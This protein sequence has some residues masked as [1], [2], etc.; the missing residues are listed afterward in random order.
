MEDKKTLYKR[1]RKIQVRIT[2]AGTLQN[3]IA[4]DLKIAK[5]SL[6]YFLNLKPSYVTKSMCDRLEKYLEE[7]GA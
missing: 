2:A 5:G 6:S 1:A 4:Q 3:K 7:K